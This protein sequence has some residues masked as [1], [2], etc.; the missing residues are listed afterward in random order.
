MGKR[1]SD[2]YLYGFIFLILVL[3]ILIVFSIRALVN[4]GEMKKVQQNVATVTNSQSDDEE[5]YEEIPEDEE[6][7]TLSESDRMK[8]YIG[9]FF[10]RIEEKDYQ[11]AYNVLN[12]DFKANYFPTLDDFKQYADNNFNT[13]IMSVTYD[14]IE[15]LGNNKTGNIYVMWLTIS[16]IFQRKIEED[17]DKLEQTNFVILE[18]DYNNYEMSFSV[19]E[20]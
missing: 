16:N 4:R 2:R 6:I 18:K 15:R 12:N 9:I 19:N 11:S 5:D 17:D 13:S 14:N 20:G 1:K 8:R 3:V 10:D 7:K